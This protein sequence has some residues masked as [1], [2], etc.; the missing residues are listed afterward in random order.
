MANV[1]KCYVYVGGQKIEARKG[2]NLRRVLIRNHSS[3]HNANAYISCRGI[4]SCGTC[5][6]EIVDGDAGEVTFMEKWRLRFPPHKIGPN[7]MRLAC[8]VT[9]TQDLHIRKH[10]GFW[11]A[12]VDGK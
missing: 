5:A 9:I 7:P 1:S 2:D 12:Y 10:A 3:P 8:Q 4:G 6:V 11:G